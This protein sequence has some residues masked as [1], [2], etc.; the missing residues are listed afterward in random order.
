MRANQPFIAQTIDGGA[1][2][3]FADLHASGTI[4]MFF[5]APAFAR[6]GVAKALMARLH[7]RASQ[8]GLLHLKAYVSLAAEPFFTAQGFVVEAR[9]AVE[10]AGIVLH[11]ARMGKSL[12]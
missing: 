2:A 3:G 6:Q 8:Q 5:V 11:N 7:A 12:S 9:Q 1:I 4:D 10:R